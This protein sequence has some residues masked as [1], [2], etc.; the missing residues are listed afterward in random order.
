VNFLRFSKAKWKILHLGGGNPKHKYRLGG[1]WLESSPEKDLV[2]VDEE[3]SMTPS[4]VR[5]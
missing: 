1:E 4:S 2:L 5:S 3:L